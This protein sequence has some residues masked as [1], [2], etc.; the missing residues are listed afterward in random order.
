MSLAYY[1]IMTASKSVFIFSVKSFVELGKKLLEVEGVQFLLSGKLNQDPLEIYFSK[2]RG[3]GG[4]NDN[5]SQGEF[6][7]NMVQLTVS[8]LHNMRTARGANCQQLEDDDNIDDAPLPRR[9]RR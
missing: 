3:M 7:R 6:E 4:R 5:P 2:Q 9:N 1:D 8:G